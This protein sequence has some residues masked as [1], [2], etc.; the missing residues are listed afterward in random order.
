MV[1]DIFVAFSRL[2]YLRKGEHGKVRR[3]QRPGMTSQWLMSHDSNDDVTRSFP[4]LFD[5]F[6]Q[7][8]KAQYNSLCASSARR[9]MKTNTRL[10]APSSDD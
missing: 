5:Y 3:V 7:Y 9:I 10:A 6:R 8:T 1:L 4:F 2:C